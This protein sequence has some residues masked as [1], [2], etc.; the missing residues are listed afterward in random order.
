MSLIPIQLNYYCKYFQLCIY[1]FQSRYPLVVKEA[2]SCMGN[3]KINIFLQKTS[4]FSDLAI[5]NFGYVEFQETIEQNNFQVKIF[6]IA[7]LSVMYHHS[8]VM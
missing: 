8:I 1:L 5:N 2:S 6:I 3:S 4:N 7:Y